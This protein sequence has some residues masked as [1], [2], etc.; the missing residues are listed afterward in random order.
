MYRLRGCRKPTARS[1]VAP[2]AGRRSARQ[3]LRG[4]KVL[5]GAATKDTMRLPEYVPS[6]FAT[7]E[8]ASAD[9]SSS[10]PDYPRRR[11]PLACR[12]RQLRRGPFGKARLMVAT[13]PRN[14]K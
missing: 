7:P 1:G 14:G 8:N 10:G 5:S 2:G 4:V 6:E 3:L 13:R 11:Q 12:Q 9:L